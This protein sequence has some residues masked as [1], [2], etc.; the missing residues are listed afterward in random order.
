MIRKGVCFQTVEGDDDD[1]VKRIFSKQRGKEREMLRDRT[2]FEFIK[3][4]TDFRI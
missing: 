1:K 3:D 2:L 4:P